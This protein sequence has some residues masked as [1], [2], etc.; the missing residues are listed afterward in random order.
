MFKFYPFLFLILFFGS[1]I[2]GPLF[3]INSPQMGFNIVSQALAEESSD[4]GDSGSGDDDEKES[5]DQ[6]DDEQ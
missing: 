2:S 4:D 6:S 1:L 3:V 5:D